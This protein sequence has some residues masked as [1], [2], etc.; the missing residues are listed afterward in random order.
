MRILQVSNGYPP[1]A[2]GGVE[3]HTQRLSRVLRERGHEV[4][5]FTRH[6]DPAGKDGDIVEEVVDQ[7]AVLSVVNDARGGKFRDHFLSA[8]V[9]RAFRRELDRSRPDL[10]HFQHLIG[11]SGDLPMIARDAGIRCVATVHEYWYACHRVMLQRED[12]TPCA[13]PQHQD[14]VACVTG[15]AAVES[16]GSTEPGILAWWPRWLRQKRSPAVGPPVASERFELLQQALACYERITTPS[17]FVVEELAR[18]GMPLPPESTR[19]IALGLPTPTAAG[20]APRQT[21]ISVEHPLRMTFIG[22]LLPH[23]GPHIL[24]MAM[25]KLQGLPIA[26][27]LH[28]RRWE[29][30]AYEATLGPLLAQEPRARARGI[31]ADE[32][33]PEILARTDVLVV[34]STCPES[35]GLATREAMLAGRPVIST[36]RGAL[37]ESIR[38]GE[39]GL[40]VAGEDPEALANAIRRL[41]E[42][43]G[44]LAHLS[45]GSRHASVATMEQYA[46]EIEEFLYS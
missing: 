43:Q 31:F 22:H 36:D 28:G 10:V 25:Q 38:E 35:F 34:P 3:T 29:Q 39:D 8:G 13:G 45:Q 16:T 42:E 12:L 24:L 1:R 30:H 17:R 6:S 23:K 40:L 27:E 11:L 26:L 19:P 18:Q 41:V 33:L 20:T 32:D 46:S 44:L 15:E 9:A 7:L 21:A 37:P 2:F 4:R 5:I 14:C